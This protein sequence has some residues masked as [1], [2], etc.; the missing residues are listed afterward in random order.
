[1][2]DEGQWRWLLGRAHDGL[3]M[4]Y[5]IS[6]MPFNLQDIPFSTERG[7][8]TSLRYSALCYEQHT[9]RAQSPI[10]ASSRNE[11]PSQ[12]RIAEVR[13]SKLMSVGIASA[14]TKAIRSHTSGRRNRLDQGVYQHARLGQWAPEVCRHPVVGVGVAVSNTS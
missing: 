10:A 1:M 6:Y 7:Y 13:A 4:F 9:I 5:T 14:S 3:Y 2:L 11:C 12:R 8:E